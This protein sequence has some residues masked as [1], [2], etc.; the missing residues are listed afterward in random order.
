MEQPG[1]FTD[2]TAQNKYLNPPGSPLPSL[3]PPS[4]SPHPLSLPLP[5]PLPLPL[6]EACLI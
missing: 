6:L 2:K 4:L 5:L 3:S 1:V